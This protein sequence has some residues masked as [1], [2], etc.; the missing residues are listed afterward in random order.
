[1]LD[2]RGFWPW[3]IPRRSKKSECLHMTE[4]SI[5]PSKLAIYFNLGIR[6]LASLD[7]VRIRRCGFVEMSSNDD[8]RS[9]LQF[10]KHRH[11][12][13]FYR[14]HQYIALKVYI[15]SSRTNR[16]IKVLEHL[17]NIKTD[18]PG[19]GSVRTMLDNFEVTG[20]KGTCQCV[21]HEPLLTSVLHL[22]AGL[23]PPSLPED[24][25]KGLLQQVLLALDYLHTEANVIHT[26]LSPLKITIL[27]GMQRRTKLTLIFRH[28]SQK[29]YCKCQREFYFQG[30]GKIRERRAMSTESY[31]RSSN[32]L[33]KP[34][35]SE[36]A[37]LA[38]L[39]NAYTI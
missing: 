16:Q 38:Q 15:H 26:G 23:D 21:V 13:T 24:L 9:V 31:T 27:H 7:S 33:P 30:L 4:T 35:I 37:G 8:C 11:T 5:I 6:L 36:Q 2:H 39:R 3:I 14:Q 18:H 34:H 25:L 20:P 1:M 22:Q 10:I 29:Y 19:R 28:T 17:S 12:L 32:Y